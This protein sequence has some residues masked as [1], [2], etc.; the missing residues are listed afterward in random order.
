[1]QVTKTQKYILYALGKWFEETNKKIKDQPLKVSISKSVFIDLVKKAKIADKQSRALYKNLET[2]EKSKL[3]S[4]KNKELELTK[5]GDNIYKQIE[6][7]I[8]PYIKLIKK[9]NQK[10]TL[11]YTRKVQ[12]VFR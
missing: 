7:D 1:M 11:K 12:T 9:I 3:I 4:Y 8:I 6:K 5:K 2:L 10:D